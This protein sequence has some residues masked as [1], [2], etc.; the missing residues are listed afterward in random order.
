MQDTKAIRPEIKGLFDTI[1]SQA[2]Q[3]SDAFDRLERQSDRVE[4]LISEMKVI[5]GETRSKVDKELF[6]L[7]SDYD[8]ITSFLR[9]ES[10]KIHKKFTEI[11]DVKTIQDS[12]LASINSLS[13][14]YDDMNE[15]FEVMKKI[16]LDTERMLNDF[17]KRAVY[18]LEHLPAN[19]QDN[20]RQLVETETQKFEDKFTSRQRHF[21][22]KLM[23]Y[24]QKLF[25]TQD[26][27]KTEFK[28]T[29]KEL[30][31]VK[32]LF[33]QVSNAYRDIDKT[34]DGHFNSLRNEIDHKIKVVDDM[35]RNIQ[36]RVEQY[37]S[38]QLKAD[39]K[40]SNEKFS[41]SGGM[42]G[43]GSTVITGDVRAFNAKLIATEAAIAEMQ[44]KT[45]TAM[46]LAI[47][48]CVGFVIA[49]IVAVI[50]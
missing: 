40:K 16:T 44:S 20:F 23:N 35:M 22:S 7:R 33:T 36:D 10:E 12:H 3:Y 27:I 5:T 45:K 8:E 43:G 34:I 19:I 50:K 17:K 21:E 49:L 15:S 14:L 31:G 37:T 25:Q 26:A 2:V 46:M 18:E 6:N 1:R 4:K 47:V 38:N 13:A 42:V 24:E 32:G 28:Q 30:D 48:G 29:F 9:N 41:D 11:D 39:I